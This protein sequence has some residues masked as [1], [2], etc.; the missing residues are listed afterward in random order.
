ME[1]KKWPHLG[2]CSLTRIWIILNYGNLLDKKRCTCTGPMCKV[3]DRIAQS[4]SIV[5]SGSKPAREREEH[6]RDGLA[7]WHSRWQWQFN[8][9]KSVWTS[10]IWKNTNQPFLPPFLLFFFTFL[11]FFKKISVRFLCTIPVLVKWGNDVSR[12]LDINFST[13]GKLSNIFKIDSPITLKSIWPSVK[14][15]I[16]CLTQSMENFMHIICY[17]EY[18]TI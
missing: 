8:P 2:V 16:T 18:T 10:W 5:A 4:T 14:L 15:F 12:L 3:W 7:V 1:C 11:P 6:P 13:T 17:R 9:Q